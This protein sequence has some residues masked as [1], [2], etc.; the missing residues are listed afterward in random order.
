MTI[1]FSSATLTYE[2]GRILFTDETSLRMPFP[3]AVVIPRP[4]GETPPGTALTAVA[5]PFV[6][7]GYPRAGPSSAR[8]FP[9]LRTMGGAVLDV[10]GPVIVLVAEDPGVFDE[11]D[12]GNIFSK[13]SALTPPFPEIGALTSCRPKYLVLQLGAGAQVIDAEPRQVKEGTVLNQIVGLPSLWGTLIAFDFAGIEIEADAALATLGSAAVAVA[14][15]PDTPN[16]VR[17]QFVDIL[18]KPLPDEAIKTLSVRLG[19]AGSVATFPSD[20]DRRLHVLS[21]PDDSRKVRIDPVAIPDNDTAADRRYLWPGARVAIWPGRG[22]QLQPIVNTATFELNAGVPSGQANPSFVRLC[23]YH[24][25]QT[26]QTAYTG[27][28]NED[29]RFAE[30]SP[31]DSSP[32]NGMVLAAE[33]DTVTVFNDGESYFADLYGAIEA[34]G[35]GDRLYITNWSTHPHLHMLGTLSRMGL[36]R[37][38]VDQSEVDSDLALIDQNRIVVAIGDGMKDFLVL[39]DRLERG[40]G[41]RVGLELEAGRVSPPGVKDKSLGKGFVRPGGL[42]AF[43]LGGEQGTLFES[44]ISAR[45]KDPAGGV[46]ETVRVLG[47]GIQPIV[48]PRIPDD[49]LALGITS[50]DPPTGTVIRTA[51]LQAVRDAIVV[52]SE[53][54]WL[55]VVNTTTGRHVVHDLTPSPNGTN[56]VLGTLPED[57]SASDTLYAI[58]LSADPGPAD[59][60]DSLVVSSGRKLKYTAAQHVAGAIP[61]AAEELGALLRRAIAKGVEVRALYWDQYLANLNG[62]EELD[63]GHSNNQ[64]MTALLNL[65]RNSRRGW[66]IRDRAT[67]AFGSFHQKGVVLVSSATTDITAWLGGIDLG[68]GKW[69]TLEHFEADPDRQGGK[70]WDVQVRLS[71]PAAIDVLRNFAQRW[72]AIGA[73]LE[74]SES[75]PTDFED[76]VPAD[77]SLE[78]RTDTQ[79]VVVTLPTVPQLVRPL[80]PE[81]SAA[82]VQITRTC[83]P[84][85]CHSK[86]GPPS[87]PGVL[88]PQGQIAAGGELGTLA[89]YIKAIGMARRFVVINDQYF[90]S[91][92]IAL[93]LHEAL[94]RVDGPSFVVVMLP[95]DLSENPKIDPM[96]FKVREKSLHILLHGGNWAAPTVPAGQLGDSFRFPH[97]GSVTANA[98][99]QPSSLA[100]RVAILYARNRAGGDVYVHSKHMIVDDVWMSVGS[101]NLNYRSTTYDFEIN[102]SVVGHLLDFGGSDL[103]RRQRIEVA[104][105]M[106]GLPAAY[107]PLIADPEVMFA[108]FKALEAKG[109]HPAHGL[110]PLAPMCQKLDPAYVKKTGDAAFDG[111]VDVVSALDFNDPTIDGIS[112][113]VID[114]DGREAKE[115]LAPLNFIATNA[116]QAYAKIILEVGCQA[117]TSGLISGGFLLLAEIRIAESNG[118]ASRTLHRVP[119]ELQGSTVVPSPSFG[120]IWV[121]ISTEVAVEIEARVVDFANVPRGCRS[122]HTVDPNQEIVIAG[123]LRDVRLTLI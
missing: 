20:A 36:G 62:D 9:Q 120:E 116:S 87:Q 72:W 70:W 25:V 80:T 11:F 26:M 94:T 44:R 71:G 57:T 97:C 107:A 10:P 86:I 2:A 56:V 100:E 74:E 119:L 61:L 35:E 78:I 45:W 90:F 75:F 103:V 79:D 82:S 64:E 65:D 52:E 19:E 53:P 123:S 16:M 32:P 83:P 77:A 110:H 67:R 34:A 30:P 18:G 117:L 114:P 37:I 115:A 13:G 6:R 47:T 69:D 66:A 55:M 85:S 93:A 68:L 29:G 15:A 5:S 118:G 48:K 7:V 40:M 21:F 24:P 73:F 108:Q 41:L 98:G 96:L 43:P 23:V 92:E 50:D 101:A 113:S 89:A 60:L 27:A 42:Y 4:A 51:I 59:G 46:H 109:D 8:R 38:D 49:A 122:T 58:V 28:L 104:R 111:N 95:K 39:S 17:V 14:M 121:P 88:E 54:L 105:R 91:P 81:A 3:G 84:R 106:L 31:T 102:A 12:L 33:A 76:C 63:S 112:C 1:P 99:T 22:A